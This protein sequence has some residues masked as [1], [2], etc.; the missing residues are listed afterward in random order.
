MTAALFDAPATTT[1]D[2]ARAAAQFKALSDVTR[3]RILQIL[4]RI[5]D[6]RP[7]LTS[8]GIRKALVDAGQGVTQPTVSY[9]MDLLSRAGFVTVDRAGIYAYYR[10]DR[11]AVVALSD[12]VR[13]DTAW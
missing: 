12:A 10:F 2:T 11:A 5:R 9:H 3:I 13:P 7:A 8:G 4:A 6:D 1:A